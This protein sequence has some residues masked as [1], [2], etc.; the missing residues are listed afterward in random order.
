MAAT[1]IDEL[2]AALGNGAQPPGPPNLVIVNGTDSG[3]WGDPMDLTEY[4]VP[5]FPTELLPSTL[6]NMAEGI[7]T[8]KQVAPD[9]AA[10]H[11][12]G[13]VSL[14]INGR[15]VVRRSPDHSEPSG[16]D[17]LVVAGPSEGKNQSFAEAFDPVFSEQARL[18]DTTITQVEQR[19]ADR[20]VLERRIA[21]TEKGFENPK[22]AGDEYRRAQ[23]THQELIAELVRLPEL[24]VEQLT[25][26]N[27]TPEAL[28]LLI[29]DNGGRMAIVSAE[30]GQFDVLAGLYN[31][32]TAVLDAVLEGYSGGRLSI[33]R[34]SGAPILIDRAY[35]MV[36]MSIQP[37]VLEDIGRNRQFAGRGLIAR[38]LIAVPPSLAGYRSARKSTNLDPG[39]REAYTT[40]MRRLFEQSTRTDD[41]TLREIT[42][43]HDAHELWLDWYDEIQ[44]LM[45][46]GEPCSPDMVKEWAGKLAGNTLRLAATFHAVE[47]VELSADILARPINSDTM[48]AAIE[49]AR[50]YFLPHFLAAAGVMQASP[51]YKLAHRI[52]KQ[53]NGR[54]LTEFTS[55][56]MQQWIGNKEAPEIRAALD[57]LTEHEIVR[58]HHERKN[59][60]AVNPQ[61]TAKSSTSSTKGPD[62][63]GNVE[64]VELLPGDEPQIATVN[65]GGGH[66]RL[67]DYRLIQD[68]PNTDLVTFAT[69]NRE[70][71]NGRF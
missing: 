12:I 22:L 5:E 58:L 40:M 37:V 8:A 44:S 39:V 6:R 19:K 52:I 60:F 2:I 53:I 28:P 50:S 51:A 21:S 57:L 24:H 20:R 67:G 43:S 17:L 4:P 34:R 9:M 33:H 36:C 10:M 59:T 68:E 63:V 29:Q 16:L 11:L 38:C 65:T 64:L 27:I 48:G 30:A 15:Y 66:E 61:I 71:H 26:T 62:S 49:I 13:A 18:R 25:T 23:A 31:G 55:R 32:G 46:D 3:S 35:V 1:Q 69:D 42:L 70:V 47:L 14:A 41:D 54:S 7:A 45:R 56:E